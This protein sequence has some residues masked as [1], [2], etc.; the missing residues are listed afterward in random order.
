MSFADYRFVITFFLFTIIYYVVPQSKR[1]IALLTCSMLFYCTWGIEWL[2][3]AVLVVC[4]AWLTALFIN[5]NQRR[6]DE[7][8]S[9]LEAKEKAALQNRAKGKNK[10]A[11]LGAA[12]VLVGLLVYIK[13]QRRLTGLICLGMSYYTLSLIG[14][15]ADVYWKKE[16]AEHNFFKLLLYALY[17]PK[18][19]E[20]PIC[21]YK[22]IAGQL[23]EGSKFDR[24]EYC[25][26]W[27]RML[28]GFFKKLVIADRLSVF[29]EGIYGNS[30]MYSGAVLL[31]ASVLGAFQLYCDFAG[32]MD[33]AIG[34]SQ[35]LGIRLEENFNRPFFSLNAAEFWRRW[36]I[37]LGTWFKDYIYM[38][39]G[40]S[41]RL[42]RISG[43]LKKRFGKRAGNAFVKGVPLMAV[44]LLTG[45]W[46]GTGWDY[47]AWG[48]FWGILIFLSTVFEPEL[49][50]MAGWLHLN[51]ETSGYKW[52]QRIRTFAL[53][54]IARILTIPGDLR[55]SFAVFG[56]IF[57]DFLPHGSVGVFLD[58]LELNGYDIII[59]F[60]SLLFMAIVGAAQE[61]GVEIRRRIAE[62]PVAVRWILWLS[63]TA[64]V[65][66]LGVYM[67]GGQTSPFIYMHY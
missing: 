51:T 53:F 2:P 42:I 14:Y 20:G 59:V 24:R 64:S 11:L 60:L 58:T 54:V 31:T 52:F 55:V 36:H 44:W 40:I 65:L 6:L 5:K 46:H 39:L 30:G 56:S 13:V 16:R 33:I 57:T 61:K 48:A 49:K 63:A 8:V 50:G 26:G 22:S 62:F 17:F 27:Q 29:V 45:L 19:L 34:A 28:W 43:K 35:V 21:K 9:G 47:I 12:A 66:I 4:V 15:M 38:P 10:Q 32:C 3:F 41:P 37:T 7:A 18:V 67:T 25:F 1:W 23:T